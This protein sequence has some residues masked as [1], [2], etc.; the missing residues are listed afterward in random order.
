MAEDKIFAKGLYVELKESTYGGFTKLSFKAEEFI[1][2]LN[3]HKNEK[4]YVN[5]NLFKNK[6][7]KSY[8]VLDTWK[9]P[10]VSENPTETSL[11]ESSDDLPFS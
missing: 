11:G 8:C 7:N 1:N 9:K 2:F 3:E 4:G 10:V 6:E 5:I